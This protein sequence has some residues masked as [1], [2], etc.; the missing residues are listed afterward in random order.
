LPLDS[1]PLDSFTL[2]SFP[3]DLP[4]IASSS[5][6]T[7]NAEGIGGTPAVPGTGPVFFFQKLIL[8]RD[9]LDLRA[10][11][12]IVSIIVTPLPFLVSLR[13]GSVAVVAM[14]C[15][16]VAGRVGQLWEAVV[17]VRVGDGLLGGCVSGET[18]VAA[19]SVE[20][21]LMMLVPRVLGD[22]GILLVVALVAWLA[23]SC[24]PGAELLL[25]VVS[26]VRCTL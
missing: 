15:S 24:E 6:P 26:L 20:S 18:V 16:E 8:N 1:F 5:A 19:R 21:L 17:L 25:S 10:R 13:P 7:G 11:L 3:L 22:R 12:R 9:R 23:Q 4:L 14:V 2:D